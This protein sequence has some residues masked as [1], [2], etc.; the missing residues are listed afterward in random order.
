[1]KLSELGEF[2][3][4]NRIAPPFVRNLPPAVIG[5][6][7]DCAVMPWR[8][9][10]CL[11][12]TTD[13]LIEDSHFIRSL[14]PAEDL[15]YKS[16]A[17]NLS[18]IAA[19]G[20]ISHSAFISIGIPPEVEVEWMDLFYRGLY[21]LASD[22]NVAL[23]GG[24]TTKSKKHLII[25][26][27]VLGSVNISQIKFRSGAQQGDI[28]CV[29]DFLGDS[30]AGLRVLLENL[31]QNKTQKY[32]V[33]RHHR[34]RP[35]IEEGIW[36]AQHDGV[37]AM[38]DVSDG[39]D[40]DIHRIMERSNCGAKV[41]LDHLPVSDPLKKAAAVNGWDIYELAATGGEDYCL[42]CSVSEEYY[43]EIADEYKKEFKRELY[44]IGVI[45]N[46]H[47]ELIYY[48]GGKSMKLAKHGFDHFARN[49]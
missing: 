33:N 30:G 37:H 48:K 29:T 31:D 7:D 2:A 16:L 45:T 10:T 11:L 13:M 20:G 41:D 18:D 39:I 4:I 25:N 43:Q 32:L 28:L 6:G 14:I 42:L 17:V 38:I 40:S 35:H 12:V 1:M 9:D 19:M 21:S 26:I 3:F 15:G 27:A 49:N 47:N 5:I 36:L 22:K 34:P 24:D 23:L 44:S 46:D 8:D